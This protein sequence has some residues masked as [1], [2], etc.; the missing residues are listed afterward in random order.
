MISLLITKDVV[1]ALGYTERADCFSI[2]SDNTNFQRNWFRP[3]Y[4]HRQ[5]YV[6]EHVKETAQYSI[7]H[8]EISV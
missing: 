8:T 2:P 7:F 1:I 3:I 5:T 4:G 6:Q